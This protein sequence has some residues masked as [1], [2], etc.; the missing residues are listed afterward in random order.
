MVL[1]MAQQAQ[2]VAP[3]TALTWKPWYTTRDSV[4]DEQHRTIFEL[5]NELGALVQAGRYDDAEVDALLRQ[6]DV[7]VDEHF[8]LEEGCMAKQACP[9]AQKNKE[10][11]SQFLDIINTF[12]TE[13]RKTKSLAT[14]QAF[15]ETASYW[16]LAHVCFVDI[17]L[18]SCGR[19]GAE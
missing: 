17:H 18:R 7:Q 11:H 9:M 1:D 4:L 12:K 3:R 5:M 6:M 8:V 13:F 16:I 10:E 2:G 14:L 15:H 19:H